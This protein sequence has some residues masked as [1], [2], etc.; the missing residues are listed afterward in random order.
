I[1]AVDH[2]VVFALEHLPAVDHLPHAHAERGGDVGRKQ[3]VDRLAGELL[4]RQPEVGGRPAVAI[5]IT[6][7]AITD[8]DRIVGRFDDRLVRLLI[9]GEVRL[10]YAMKHASFLAITI[11]A[12]AVSAVSAGA[13]TTAPPAGERVYRE[14]CASC[15]HQTTQ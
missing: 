9:H 4:L 5:E 1:L 10:Y 2:Q 12:F 7:V 14:R 3:V 11:S 6:S 15:H 8:E 13:Q